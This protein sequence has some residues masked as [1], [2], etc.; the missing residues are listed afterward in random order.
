MDI[1]VLHYLLVYGVYV[2][3]I[4]QEHAFSEYSLGCC[5]NLS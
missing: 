5:I 4:L 2:T 1:N 3:L